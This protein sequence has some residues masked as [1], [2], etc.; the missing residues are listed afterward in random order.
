MLTAKASRKWSTWTEEEDL[1][2]NDL[3]V[4]VRLIVTDSEGVHSGYDWK[5]VTFAAIDEV[6]GS[7]TQLGFALALTTGVL[8]SLL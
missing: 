7:A 1:S 3:Y 6:L 8:M 5:P 4:M 2:Y